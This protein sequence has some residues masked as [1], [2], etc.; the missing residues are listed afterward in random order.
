MERLKAWRNGKDQRSNGADTKEDGV[1][2]ESHI[3]PK[4]AE[5]Q[6]PPPYSFSQDKPFSDGSG[7]NGAPIES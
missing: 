1:D 2:L 4:Q 5:Q 6:A 3:M 7:P